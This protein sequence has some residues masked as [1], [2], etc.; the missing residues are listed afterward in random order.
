ME[1]PKLD[2]PP[3]I[4]SP[5]EAINWVQELIV[6]VED[7]RFLCDDAH[8]KS[9]RNGARLQRRAFRQFCIHWGNCMGAASTLMRVGLLT[10]AQ[11]VE[12]RSGLERLLLPSV[13]TW[14]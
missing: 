5:E 9:A 10:E 12:L 4:N 11:F 6:K 8:Y 13:R 3:Q 1:S 7:K 14:Q 2:L